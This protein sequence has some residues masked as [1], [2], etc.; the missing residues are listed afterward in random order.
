MQPDHSEGGARLMNDVQLW[1]YAA[2][3]TP[4]DGEA[5]IV[6]PVSACVARTREIAAAIAARAIPAEHEAHIAD[7]TV[8]IRPF[9]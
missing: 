6:V 3:Y 7:I 5:T 4:K 2:I 8:V 9:G 1:E